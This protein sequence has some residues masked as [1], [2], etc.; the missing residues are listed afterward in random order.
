MEFELHNCQWGF[1]KS[2]EHDMKYMEQLKEIGFTFVER[3]SYFTKV[4]EYCIDT[5]K[6]VTIEINSLTELLDFVNKF[7]KIVF[8]D[9]YIEIYDDHR[10]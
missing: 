7:G 9:G 1:C 10:E 6:Q 4:M 2:N 3:E 5:S 8:N